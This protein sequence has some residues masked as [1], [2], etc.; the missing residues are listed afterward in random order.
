MLNTMS[1]PRSCSGETS[2]KPTISPVYFLHFIPT[3]LVSILCMLPGVV[4]TFQSRWH[5][6]V[7]SKPSSLPLL[8]SA[9]RL[10]T[11]STRPQVY[12]TI[13]QPPS[14]IHTH[15]QCL[16]QKTYP[17]WFC[18][19]LEMDLSW[20]QERRGKGRERHSCHPTALSWNHEQSDCWRWDRIE[21][22]MEG[23]LHLGLPRMP[24]SGKRW[25][26]QRIQGL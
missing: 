10:Y 24:R 21:Q 25:A 20:R 16:F 23:A 8:W 5:H 17:F 13:L 4:S 7:I 2:T 11:S 18:N 1:T 19:R 15:S 26:A 12:S 22:T 6:P 3:Q 14:F 9:D